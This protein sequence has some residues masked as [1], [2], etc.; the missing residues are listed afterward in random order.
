MRKQGVMSENEEEHFEELKEE[1]TSE[2][3]LNKRMSY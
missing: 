2:N 3:D 1:F